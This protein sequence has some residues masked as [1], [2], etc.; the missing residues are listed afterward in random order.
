MRWFRQRW[1]RSADHLGEKLLRFIIVTPV[2]SFFIMLFLSPCLSLNET[3]SW[4]ICATGGLFVG[5][6]MALV[7]Q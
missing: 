3:A 5:M 2:I 4:A 7:K 6:A 1:S